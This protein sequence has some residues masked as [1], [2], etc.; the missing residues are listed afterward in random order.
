MVRVQ[1]RRGRGAKYTHL[2]KDPAVDRWFRNV[3]RGSQVTADVYLRRLGHVCEAHVAAPESLVAMK[4]EERRDFLADLVSEMEEA[5]NAGSYVLSTLRAVKSWLAFNGVRVDH[6][7]NVKGAQTTP[8]LERERVPTQDEL[9][10][11]FLA[12]SPRERSAAALMAHAGLRPGTMGDYRGQDGLGLGDLPDLTIKGKTIAFERLPARVVVR[13]SLSKSGRPY[14]SFIGPETA[15]YLKQ[16]LESRLRDGERLAGDSDVVAPAW[17]KKQFLSSINVSDVVRKA[18]RAAG[19]RWRPY[20][21]RAYFDSQLLLAESRGKMTHAYRQFF[22]GHSGDIE[23]RYTVNKGRLPPD[24]IEDMRDAYRRSLPFLETI[25]SADHEAELKT[26][27]RRQMLLVAGLSEAEVG[28]MDIEAMS[29][30]DLQRIVRDKLLGSGAAN[31]AE[32]GTGAREKVVPMAA[33]EQFIESGWRWV[34]ALPD[35]RAVLR[36]S[37]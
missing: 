24:L 10:R 22:M 16:Y 31:G 13:G 18:M 4:A 9:H 21:L 14:F 5:D 6:T 19:F 29:D 11:I 28:K 12:A 37:G 15:G 26:A 30:A 36:F 35:D 7:I 3:A 20:V 1:G 2:L 33:V 23:A 17:S 25:R 32:S 27:F 34:A 8:T